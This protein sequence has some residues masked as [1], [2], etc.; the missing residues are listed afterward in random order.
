MRRRRPPLI[1]DELNSAARKP[2]FV[3]WVGDLVNVFEPKS[4]ANFRR[5]AKM[6]KMPNILLHGNHDTRPPYEG[7]TQLQKELTGVESP[8]LFV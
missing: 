2:E 8:F 6:F 4:V 1:A 7:Y 3:V 5:L